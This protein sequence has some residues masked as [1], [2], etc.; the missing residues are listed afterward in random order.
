MINTKD[1]HKK[2]LQDLLTDEDWLMDYM[3]D[4]AT[5]LGIDISNKRMYKFRSTKIKD[6]RLPPDFP[7][8]LFKLFKIVTRYITCK[9]YNHPIQPTTQDELLCCEFRALQKKILDEKKT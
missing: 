2:S 3:M 9:K 6:G 5:R 7:N 4:I 1:L 8:K